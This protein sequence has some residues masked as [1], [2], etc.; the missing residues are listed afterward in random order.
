MLFFIDDSMTTGNIVPIATPG[1]TVVI[2]ATTNPDRYAYRAAQLLHGYG[3]PMVLVGVREGQVAGHPILPIATMP[4][5]ADVDTV[6]IYLGP[7]NL[8]QWEEYIL[9]LHPR[10]IL[11]NPGAENPSFAARAAAAGIEVED[12]CTLVLLQ[13]GEY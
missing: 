1:K 3:Y 9:S 13:L 12:A 2:G 4:A 7:A 5:I 6:T 11:F 8:Q 10:R